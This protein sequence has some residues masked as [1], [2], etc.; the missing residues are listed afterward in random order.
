MLLQNI[1]RISDRKVDGSL[2]PLARFE[3]P[4]SKHRWASA[5]TLSQ[6]MAYLVCGDKTGSVLLYSMVSFPKY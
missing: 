1:W 4:D 6:D 5:A 2:Q 3:L